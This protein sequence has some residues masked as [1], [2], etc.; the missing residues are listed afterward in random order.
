MV[1]QQYNTPP[2]LIVVW[3]TDNFADKLD[4]KDWYE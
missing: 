2:R 3:K 4:K 1:A